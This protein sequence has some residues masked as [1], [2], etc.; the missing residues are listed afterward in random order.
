MDFFPRFTGAV[1]VEG[2]EFAPSAAIRGIA[3]TTHRT[4]RC[5]GGAKID[6]RLGVH[7]LLSEDRRGIE[8]RSEHSEGDDHSKHGATAGERN[9]LRRDFPPLLNVVFPAWL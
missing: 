7:G 9:D 3:G 6:R 2:Q 1:G 5:V 8:R 4:K